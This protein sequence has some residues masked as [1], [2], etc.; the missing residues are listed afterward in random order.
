MKK[1]LVILSKYHLRLYKNGFLNYAKKQGVIIEFFELHDCDDDNILFRKAYKKNILGYRD[2]INEKRSIYLKTIR[3]EYNSFLF[4]N[5]PEESKKLLNVLS[6]NVDKNILFVD[7]MRDLVEIQGLEKFRNICSFEYNDVQ[8]AKQKWGI[9]VNYTPIGTSYHLYNIINREPQYDISFVCLVSEKRLAYLDKIADYCYKNNRTLF[10]AGHFW[11]NEN[12]LQRFIGAFKFRRKHP[13]L[14]RYVKNE[15][16]TPE[17]LAQVYIDSK[18]CLNINIEK[19]HSF[20]TRNFDIMILGRLLI[21]DE[22]DLNGIDIKRDKDFIMSNNSDHMVKLIDYYLKN[23]K[24]RRG[25]AKEGERKIK[26]KYT[27]CDTM[28]LV[29]RSK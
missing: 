29:L 26:T 2:N 28:Q 9:K 3:K 6:E 23:E 21:T 10:C 19:H 14:Y 7:T 12:F 16:L 11:H 20:N 13:I 17:Q 27:F 4:I 18:I 25:I 5:F 1:I 24:S 8:Y 22:E 15:Y